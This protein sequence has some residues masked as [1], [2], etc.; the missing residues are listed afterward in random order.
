MH[1]VRNDAYMRHSIKYARCGLTYIN[2]KAITFRVLVCLQRNFAQMFFT[3][4]HADPED[5]I[6]IDQNFLS[7]EVLVANHI[8]RPRLQ[9]FFKK[10]RCEH[11]FG[12]TQ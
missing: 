1:R 2:A 7:Y 11:L 4:R 8:A 6:Q 10:V 12:N 3:S 9:D 5:F